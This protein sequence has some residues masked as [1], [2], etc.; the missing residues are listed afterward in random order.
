MP[1]PLAVTTVQLLINNQKTHITHLE[2]EVEQLSD[3]NIIQERV[4]SDL[5]GVTEQLNWTLN[6]IMSYENFPVKLFCPGHSEWEWQNEHVC[7]VYVKRMSSNW[8][9][10]TLCLCH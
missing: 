10:V 7:V 5:K 2:V 1:L 6:V 9:S 8:T 4:N 3:L